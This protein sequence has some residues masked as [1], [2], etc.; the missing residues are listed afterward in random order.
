MNNTAS[1]WKSL[2]P[3]GWIASDSVRGFIAAMPIVIFA[4]ALR[5][6]LQGPAHPRTSM[7]G[8]NGVDRARTRS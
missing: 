4:S 8:S 1:I 5:A 6:A 2:K 3:T 7:L